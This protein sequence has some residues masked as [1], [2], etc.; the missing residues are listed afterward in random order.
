LYKI[1]NKKKRK[2]GFFMKKRF[3]LISVVLSAVMAL[4]AVPSM[5]EEASSTQASSG[6]TKTVYPSNYAF[7]GKEASIQANKDRTIVNSPII[8]REGKNTT[9]DMFGA[10]NRIYL[11]SLNFYPSF[12][13]EDAYAI[14]DIKLNM[15]RHEGSSYAQ[16]GYLISDEF[17]LE[18]TASGEIYDTE[19][20]DLYET[21]KGYYN[22][23]APIMM[24]LGKCS[25]FDENKLGVIDVSDDVISELVTAEETYGKAVL[26]LGMRGGGSIYIRPASVCLTITYD[27]SK[28]LDAFQSKLS[29]ATTAEAVKAVAEE[30]SS[31][32]DADV[33]VLSNMDYVYADIAKT[34]ATTQYTFETFAA[35]IEN[36]AKAY[37]KEMTYTPDNYALRN[38]YDGKYQT[39]IAV[40]TNA[41]PTASDA[42]K[43][44][45]V[46][47]IKLSLWRYL[48]A[49]KLDNTD[50]IREIT[51]NTSFG[52]VGDWLKF[53]A[54]PVSSFPVGSEPAFYGTDASEFTN[55]VS[56]IEKDLVTEITDGSVYANTV[57]SIDYSDKIEALNN[58]AGEDN[59]AVLLAGVASRTGGGGGVVQ[60]FKDSLKVAY[61][62]TAINDKYN[63]DFAAIENAADVRA[64]V[65]IYN[66]FL[67]VNLGQLKNMDVVYAELF[68]NI[69]K[70]EVYSLDTLKKAID[71]AASKYIYV[72]EYDKPTD[73]Y[74]YKRNGALDAAYDENLMLVNSSYL[75]V[76][77][78]KHEFADQY[79]NYKF[80]DSFFDS[81]FAAPILSYDIY[82]PQAI[83]DVKFTTDARRRKET[84]VWSGIAEYST[85]VGW[86]VS[87][88]DLTDA[89]SGRYFDD[90]ESTTD[91]FDTLLNWFNSNKDLNKTEYSVPT[92]EE[93]LADPATTH[94]TVMDI[95][96]VVMSQLQEKNATTKLIITFSQQKRQLTN[97]INNNKLT[98][99]YD[100]SAV[101]EAEKEFIVNGYDKYTT[102][103]DSLSLVNDGAR[104]ELVQTKKNVPSTS[105]AII[106]VYN[107]GALVKTATADVTA[108]GFMK[109]TVLDLT[110][111]ADV[112]YDSVKVM[113]WDGISSM[114]P[115]ATAFEIR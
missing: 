94:T 42:T 76:T 108:P 49:Y 26:N 104:V 63:A 92:G 2:V 33:N 115:L 43:T 73:Y 71:E 79:I 99:T 25:E 22:G 55:L 84:D 62:M 70:G 29:K 9:Y 36:G 35:A 82:N 91:V 14:S 89:K 7:A 87:D 80:E 50:A 100:L 114:K 66:D 58:V 81:Y 1:S 52:A 97:G 103:E 102:S 17:I 113:T 28:I 56:Y 75:H 96:E 41:I 38:M 74:V 112:T 111:F 45:D 21:V 5:A 67:G 61:D 46:S 83:V 68:E 23:D 47:S 4:S 60:L 110:G 88:A 57:A 18:G 54:T 48:S 15:V 59:S 107:Q 11:Y 109:K 78:D 53:Y 65:E 95:P 98:I 44:E 72:V 101:N 16:V 90:A 13:I 12:E 39:G 20:S 6:V 37:L 85:H 34:T 3:K 19:E 30:Y 10:T 8:T 86:N 106:A 51:L 64:L 93:F 105:K 31:Y 24:N 27:S 77:N 40:N 69:S 32:I